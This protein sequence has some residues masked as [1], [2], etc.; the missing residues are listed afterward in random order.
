[1]SR[2]CHRRSVC[3]RMRRRCDASAFPIGVGR[4]SF[5]ECAVQVRSAGMASLIRVPPAPED[6]RMNIVTC[7]HKPKWRWGKKAAA[8]VFRSWPVALSLILSGCAGSMGP[9]RPGPSMTSNEAEN[10]APVPAL[11]KRI[12]PGSPEYERAPYLPLPP[13]AHGSSTPPGTRQPGLVKLPPPSLP[14]PI[15]A[16]PPTQNPAGQIY[17]TPRG[18]V[19]TTGGTTHYQTSVTPG[20]GSAVIIPGNGVST[21]IRSDGRVVVVPSPR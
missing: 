12:T 4:N 8:V 11:Q 6:R 3:M 7:P 1:M 2:Q 15:D 10:T 18:A 9:V 21:I 14:P 20:G 17:W 5:A 13:A 19:V 16:S